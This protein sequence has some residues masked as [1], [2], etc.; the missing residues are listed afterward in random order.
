VTRYPF[1]DLSANLAAFCDLL[2]R[3]H[4]FRLGPR[5]LRDAARALIVA[6]LADERA[7]RDVLRPI[8][9]HTRDDVL[10]FDEAFLQFFLP[11]LTAP[12]PP[13]LPGLGRTSTSPSR[14]T[15]SPRL[16]DDGQDD[17][18]EASHPGSLHPA[19]LSQEDGANGADRPFVRARYS[20]LDAQGQ[21]PELERPDAASRAAARA[22]VDRLRVR[23]SRRWLPAPH[24]RRFDLRRTLRGSLHTG[25]EAVVPRWRARLR[26]QPRLVVLIDG[27]RSMGV[28]ASRALACAVA[29][30]AVT[31]RIEVFTFSTAVRQITRDVRRAA[32]G[33]AHRLPPVGYAWGGGTSIGASLR[34]LLTRWGASLLG[35]ETVVVIAS[36]GLE[37]GHPDILRDAMAR[38]HR[39]S[40][41]I[42]WLNPL[43]MTAGYEPTARGMRIARPF[44]TTFAWA[45]DAAGFRRLSQIV[46]LRT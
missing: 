10:A 35:D 24:G 9:C 27:S 43:L 39:E 30:A 29:L 34:E 23:L 41:A 14:D 17:A 5:E 11:G 4:G 42:I 18:P 25:G 16:R 6:P 33:E 40:A 38:L 19:E 31:S 26:R 3:D 32:A 8:L 21:P 15:T 13:P 20:P 28:E 46:R 45:G 44:I 1:A 37:V 7:V 12:V 22:L 36:D 2:R